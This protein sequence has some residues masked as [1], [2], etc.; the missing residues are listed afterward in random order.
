MSVIADPWQQQWPGGVYND[1]FTKSWLEQRDSH[2]H[3]AHSMLSELKPLL[4]QLESNLVT[5]EPAAPLPAQPRA[6]EPVREEEYAQGDDEV[7]QA[8]TYQADEIK[9][10]AQY[11]VVDSVGEFT[12]GDQV[13]YGLYEHG[14]FGPFPPMKSP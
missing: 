14:F 6:E 10:L 13:G 9:G 5:D 4:E 12:Y 8:L 3:A 2:L 1:G 11:G 7:V